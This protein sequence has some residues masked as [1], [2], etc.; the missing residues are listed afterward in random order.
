MLIDTIELYMLI[1]VL[2]AVTFIQ[3]H[4]CARKQEYLRQ[5]SQS[6]QSIWIEF[7]VVLSLGV[8][9]L[10]LILSYPLNIQGREPWFCCWL[11]FFQ[12]WYDDRD[13]KAVHFDISLN[14]LDLHSRSQFYEN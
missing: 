11:V 3:G 14:D 2:L 1:L 6:F 13:L 7:G 5:L 4:R 8:M 9:N 10:V 12:T